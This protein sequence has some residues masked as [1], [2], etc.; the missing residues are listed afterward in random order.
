MVEF[1]IRM[2][3]NSATVFS[4]IFKD[5]FIH[6]LPNIFLQFSL[7]IFFLMLSTVFFNLERYFTK[8]AT[9]VTFYAFLK[10]DINREQMDKLKNTIQ[11]WPE[12]NNIRI[13]GK[14][15]GILMLKKSLGKESGIL[16]TLDSNPLPVTLEINVKAGFT[17]KININQITG[18]LKKFDK[19]E[20]IDTTEKYLGNILALKNFA[21]IT[22][23]ASTIFFIILI[24]LSLKIMSG[25][26]LYRYA[27]SV[28][29]LM[30]LGASY[31]FIA[32]PFVFEGA[33]ES[34]IT[35]ISAVAMT[36]YIILDIAH[37]LI[38]FNIE[39]L[40]LPTNVY[41][42]FIV[43]VTLIGA[44]SSLPTKKVKV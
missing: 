41:I 4:I 29:L 40:N 35:S 21:I 17:D 7:F 18:R 14:D 34:F 37:K 5:R 22:F 25:R 2:I 42:L 6:R 30:F 28:K 8:T 9:K 11:N 16:N 3:K 24:V 1:M 13:I 39:I 12:I 19:I 33:L 26:L 44:L 31:K 20:W 36:N 27:Q 43:S 10:D 38:D 15:E 32:L 23:S